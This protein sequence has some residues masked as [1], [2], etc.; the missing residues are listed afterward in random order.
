MQ[1]QTGF[2]T[3]RSTPGEQETLVTIELRENNIRVT[4]GLFY[5]HNLILKSNVLLTFNDRFGTAS[6]IFDDCFL[7]LDFIH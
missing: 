6:L 1:T 2:A 4:A 5:I 7:V 3:V